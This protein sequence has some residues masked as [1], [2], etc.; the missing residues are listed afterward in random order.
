MLLLM[1]TTLQN[2]S[3][4]LI[5]ETILLKGFTVENS[6]EAGVGVIGGAEGWQLRLHG[7]P[8]VRVML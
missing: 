6:E 3:S 5:L 1:V 2:R 4:Q 7:S 8:T